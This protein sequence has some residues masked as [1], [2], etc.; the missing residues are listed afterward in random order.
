[1]KPSVLLIN[2]MYLPPPSDLYRPNAISFAGA[3]LYALNRS[4]TS[5]TKYKEDERQLVTYLLDIAILSHSSLHM[6]AS[7]MAAAAVWLACSPK[8][9]K[10]KDGTATFEA[11]TGFSVEELGPCLTHL[12]ALFVDAQLQPHLY[13]HRK[14][15]GVSDYILGKG[16]SE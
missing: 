7:K 15:S 1:M 11:T 8:L 12:S 2:C 4:P 10:E 9:A 14:H 13:V 6:S 5:A 16:T 3:F